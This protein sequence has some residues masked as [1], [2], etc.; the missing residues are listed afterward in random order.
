VVLTD[1]RDGSHHPFCDVAFSFIVPADLS[2]NT[3]HHTPN[4]DFPGARRP[5]ILALLLWTTLSY[6]EFT[7]VPPLK[8]LELIGTII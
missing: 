7:I 4:E 5:H 2:S 3:L 6:G 1:S 8:M